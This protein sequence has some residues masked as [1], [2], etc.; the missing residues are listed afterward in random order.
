M[1]R[2]ARLQITTPCRACAAPIELRSQAG[3][4]LHPR[5]LVLYVASGLV[6]I[7]AFGVLS[8]SLPLRPFVESLMPS[9]S[10]SSRTRALFTV[11]WIAIGFAPG[12]VVGVLA[13]KVPRIRTLRCAECGAA[14]TLT[15]IQMRER[16]RS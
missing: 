7:A 6:V 3:W 4:R 5:A 12:V 8:V 9:D 14:D 10:G 13:S 15:T 11:V 16:L 2:R 1:S